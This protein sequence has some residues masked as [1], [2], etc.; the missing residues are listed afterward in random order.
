MQPGLP[1]RLLA[2]QAVAIFRYDLLDI[3]RVLSDVSMWRYAGSDTSLE[4]TDPTSAQ[5]L[6]G[7]P[8]YVALMTLLAL[9]LGVLL[10]HSGAAVSTVIALLF[11]LPVILPGFGIET[12]FAV[13]PSNTGQA[14]MG[15]PAPYANSLSI[16]LTVL[17]AAVPLAAG[18]WSLRRRDA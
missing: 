14:L 1:G 5:V 16:G 18:I 12:L 15:L 3:D 8:I 4:I 6:L 7:A 17:W 10:R 2:A 13:L 9:G 11:F